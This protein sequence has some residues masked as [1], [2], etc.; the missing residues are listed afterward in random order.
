VSLSAARA[1]LAI[2]HDKSS[3]P[4]VR[5]KSGSFLW[6]DDDDLIGSW[7][8]T[9]GKAK[10]PR[11]GRRIDSSGKDEKEFLTYKGKTV[12][13]PL[14]HSR[15]DALI[16]LHTLA[17]LVRADS[18]VRFC[19]D[20][21]HSSDLAFL[22]L[23]PDQWKALEK[24][25]GRKAIAYRFLPF[26]KDLGKFLDEA[27]SEKHNRKYRE[28]ERSGV[29]EKMA[30]ELAAYVTSL[31]RVHCP[32]AD[33]ACELELEAARV[34]R[35]KIRT[36]TDRERDALVKDRKRIKQIASTAKARCAE[37]DVYL[38]IAWIQSQESVTR[39]FEGNWRF[40]ALAGFHML[41][42]R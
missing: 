26:P 2:P 12:E 34:M 29:E 14:V 33:V 37:H 35:L 5:E 21:G 15:D 20:S 6:S 23:A 3:W 41:D 19:V 17:G 31:A 25:F 30:Q 32:T 11:A 4:L 28:P 42:P 40:G 7:N 27:F 36:K 16:I 10:L 18:D 38:S 22:A 9:A 24:E 13:V 8:K 1:I 39:D